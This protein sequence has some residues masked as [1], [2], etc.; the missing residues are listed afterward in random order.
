M[1]RLVSVPFTPTWMISCS[2]PYR[3]GPVRRVQEPR[4]QAGRETAAR[5]G[6]SPF[7]RHPDQWRRLTS[8]GYGDLA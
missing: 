8:T 3:P 2:P 6:L 5:R 4:F 1:S 7:H